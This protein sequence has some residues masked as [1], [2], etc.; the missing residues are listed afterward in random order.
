MKKILL[1]V[2]L[3]SSPLFAKD[4][5]DL[6]DKQQVG[7]YLVTSYHGMLNTEGTTL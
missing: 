3:F 7:R 1:V 6:G 2:L 4:F 5:T